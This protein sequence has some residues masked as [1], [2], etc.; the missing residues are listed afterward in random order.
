MQDEYHTA[1]GEQAEGPHPSE[2][3]ETRPI[4]ASME[5]RRAALNLVERAE[6][7]VVAALPRRV[8]E[9]ALA[10]AVGATLPHLRYAFRTARGASI[11]AALFDL[12]L[13]HARDVLAGDPSLAPAAAA[14]F[15][16]FGHLGNFRR[17]FRQ[18]FGYDPAEA[19]DQGPAA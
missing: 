7:A 18:R 12:R 3:R 4:S 17:A 13:R 5:H 10:D 19:A 2:Q 1:Q 15:C 9:G 11:Y 8:D 14:N 16:G 6:Q